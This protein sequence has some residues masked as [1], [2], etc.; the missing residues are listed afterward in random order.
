M[1]NLF[2]ANKANYFSSDKNLLPLY[3]YFS[4]NLK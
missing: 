3:Q 1:K 4:K 2:Y